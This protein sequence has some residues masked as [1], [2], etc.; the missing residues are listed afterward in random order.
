MQ[1]LYQYFVAG[2]E[3]DEGSFLTLLPQSIHLKPPKVLMHQLFALQHLC[4]IV[5]TQKDTVENP[6]FEFF[7]TC[8]G[9]YAQYKA[10]LHHTQTYIMSV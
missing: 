6:S 2:V 9:H 7:D 1:L 10:L 4:D 5:Y 3:C 8:I